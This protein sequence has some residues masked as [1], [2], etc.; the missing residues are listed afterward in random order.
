MKAV[1]YSKEIMKHF[2]HPKNIGLMENPSGVG[3]VGNIVCGD[4]LWLYLKVKNN[5]I[6]DSKV[7]TF[8]C[9]VAIANSSI[10]TTMIKGKGLEE[11]LKITK[12][13]VIKKLGNP[14]PP[15]KIHCSVLAVEALHEAIYDYYSRNKLRIPAKLKKEHERAKQTLEHIEHEHKEYVD[16]EKKALKAK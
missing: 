13:D 9:I 10:I 8:G 1:A 6:L 2:F 3:K 15:I 12:D 14:L 5:K 11:A 4:V 16:L 7:Q